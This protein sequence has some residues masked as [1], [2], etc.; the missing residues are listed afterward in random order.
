MDEEPYLAND[1]YGKDFRKVFEIID[2]AKLTAIEGMAL[3]LFVSSARAPDKASKYVQERISQNSKSSTLE[4]ILRSIQKDLTVLSKKMC[5]DDDVGPE[6]EA[7]VYQRDGGRCF[8][9]GQT[10]GV[11]PTYIVA[12]SILEDRD[13]KPG[14][15][16]R[17]LLE[18]AIT[19]D[20]TEQMF[21]LLE[22]SRDR[23]SDLKNLLLMEPSVQH[24]FRNGHFE[25]IKSPYLESPYL[26]KDA[27]KMK[28]GGWWIRRTPP[29]T[30]SL[31]LLPD[32]DELYKV[33]STVDSDSHPLPAALLLQIHGIVSRP[34]RILALEAQIEAGWP[35]KTPEPRTLGQT[36]KFFLR[37]TLHFLPN[38]ARVKLYEFID[39]WVDYWDPKQK[40]AH[41]KNLPLGLCLKRGRESTENEANA[42]LLAEKHTSINA[43]RLIDSVM[44][45]ETSGFILMTR[46]FGDQLD[47]VFCL[48][49]WEE[50]KQIGKDLAK[51]IAEMRRIPNKS[52]YL[53]ANTLGGPISDHRF[54]GEGWGPF[55]AISDFTDRLVRDVTKPRNERP[56]S[57]LYERKHD[58]CFTH[59]DLHMSNLFIT[60]GRLSGIID[61]EN[62]G[63]KPEYWEFTRSMWPYGGDVNTGYMYR[64]A[65]DDKYEE[66]YKAEACILLNSPFVF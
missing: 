64:C 53:I 56:I 66:E 41:V 62:A 19:K 17:P 63:F 52:N 50:R 38:F 59:S 22:E 55:N 60:G 5:H 40:G 57:V 28:N 12:P 14:G 61:W 24:V 9:T 42:L 45:D 7:A 48:T 44:I 51:W 4:E 31:P 18:A 16:L 15:Y 47:N 33:P 39:R 49:T 1:R 54:S 37:T 11:K 25:I 6:V 35:T 21:A 46:I 43:P 10:V 58:V 23:K 3:T 29:G 26:P 36:G 34:L 8:I 20:E 65:F 32:D 27:P 2:S 30:I 13:L